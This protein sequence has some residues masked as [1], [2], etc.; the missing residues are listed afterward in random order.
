MIGINNISNPD[1]G[2]FVEIKDDEIPVFWPCGVTPINVLKKIQ[3]PFAI[4][5]SP[6]YMLIADKKDSE[7]YV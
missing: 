6:G 3:L 4:T 5:H 7:Y 2:D 1:Y